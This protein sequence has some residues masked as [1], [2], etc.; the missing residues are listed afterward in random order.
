VALGFE[1]RASRWLGRHLR[2]EPLLQ[3]PPH[4]RFWSDHGVLG[5][6]DTLSYVWRHVYSL[7]LFHTPSEQEI[8]KKKSP[9]YKSKGMIL[10]AP[11]RKNNVCRDGLW[12][13]DSL[14]PQYIISHCQQNFNQRWNLLTAKGFS[15]F[16]CAHLLR[17][18]WDFLS[19][20][21]LKFFSSETDSWVL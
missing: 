2:F 21:L 9:F 18:T 15:F 16:I 12:F 11:G 19:I 8:P 13:S 6:V 7:D 10:V 17:I 14:L 5:F 3:Q 20:Q 4:T 1:L